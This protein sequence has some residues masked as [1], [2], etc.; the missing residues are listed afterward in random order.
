MPNYQ[1]GMIYKLC[2]NDLNITDIYIGSTVCFK[3]RKRCHKK[4]CNNINNRCYNLKVYKFI[5]DNGGWNN[6]DMVLVAKT[7]CN[8]KL[9][10]LQFER[11]YYE[12]LNSTLNNNYPGRTKKEW[13][14]KNKD[15]LKI[16]KK[17]WA[18]KN[19]DIIK[20]K[21][22][23]Y[24]KSNKEKIIIHATEYKKKNK[25][26]IKKY[27][28]EYNKD[29]NEILKIKQKKYYGDN[30]DIIINRTKK[31]YEKNK[32]IISQKRKEYREENKEK[33]K[34]QSKKYREK[35]K[36][37]IKEKEL[38]KINCPLCGTLGIKK[39][40][41]RHQKTLKCQNLRKTIE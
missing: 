25:I 30:K 22:K 31:Y 41:K 18:E 5:R 13:R 40:L 27:L 9:E 35:N 38:I 6:W 12:E 26:K 28:K 1:N 34:I 39:K 16:K 32:E 37:K 19:K 2:C 21:Y 15:I 17:E 14:E 36:I 3:E 29:N 4:S 8:S 11:K 24:Y 33:I 20:I 10:L 23:K 7:P